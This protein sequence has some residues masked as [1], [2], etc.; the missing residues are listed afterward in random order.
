MPGMPIQQFVPVG[1]DDALVRAR[2]VCEWGI[3]DTREN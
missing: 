3:G 2:E 1:I